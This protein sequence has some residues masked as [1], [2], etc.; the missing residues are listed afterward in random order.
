[1]VCSVRLIQIFP[2][3]KK[4]RQY[5]HFRRSLV[6]DHSYGPFHQSTFPP[7]LNNIRPDKDQGN[8]ATGTNQSTYAIKPQPMKCNYSHGLHP[9]AKAI[10]S[11]VHGHIT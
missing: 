2:L 5:L 1:M 8:V 3:M 4:S 9:K 7:I 6:Q 10:Q 11:Y